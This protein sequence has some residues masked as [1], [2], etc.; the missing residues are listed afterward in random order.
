M[1]SFE[2]SGHSSF[3]WSAILALLGLSAGAGATYIMGN[4]GTIDMPA[5]ATPAL[6]AAGHG[7]IEFDSGTNTFQK[8]ENGGGYF[9]LNSG[10]IGA[11]APAV[12]AIANIN[13]SGGTVTVTTSAQHN[14]A[15]GSIVTVAAVTHTQC[16]TTAVVTGIGSPTVFSYAIAPVTFSI[17]SDSVNSNNVEVDAVPAASYAYTAGDSFTVAAVTRTQ[18][19]GTFVVTSTSI[20][21]GFTTI[22]YT[23]ATGNAGNAADTGSITVAGF[24]VTADTGTVTPIATTQFNAYSI[25]P[26]VLVDA[27]FTAT[28]AGRVPL[29]VMGAAGQ[30]ANLQDWYDAART[31]KASVTAAGQF[32]GTLGANYPVLNGSNVFTGSTNTL[33]RLAVS[34]SQ[35]AGAVTGAGT[36]ATVTFDSGGTD[37]AFI[38]IV[39]AGGSSITSLG[40]LTIMLNAAL[41]SNHPVAVATLN[42]DG[43]SGA[44]NVRATIM[45]STSSTSS[46]VFMWDN[47]SAALTAAKTYKVSVHIFG[48]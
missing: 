4:V 17:A 5:Q 44:W 45:Q 22:F 37:T 13:L 27:Q 35:P 8:S 19:N 36:T 34:G 39:T 15:V 14:L 40:T 47:N 2:Q 21:G 3:I 30:T 16:N 31:L 6:S 12:S 46:V 41:A 32:T 43:I 24:G 25:T 23:L 7:R 9:P 38:A 1:P 18:L 33:R 29:A 11:G 42:N 48:K 28:A 26:D 10:L 20:G